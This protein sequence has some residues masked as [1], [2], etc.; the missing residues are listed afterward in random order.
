MTKVQIFNRPLSFSN[1]NNCH[2]ALESAFRGLR[3]TSQSILTPY[4][5]GIQ[6]CVSAESDTAKATSTAA[7]LPLSLRETPQSVTIVTRE[8]FDDQNLQSLQ[9]VL[10]TVSASLNWRF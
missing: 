4:W 3:R 9:D 1:R 6:T 5:L 2:L 8:R 7:K 10:D